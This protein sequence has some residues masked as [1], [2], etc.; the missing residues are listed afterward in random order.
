MLKFEQQLSSKD[1]DVLRNL[2]SKRNFLAA[3]KDYRLFYQ[4]F[5][6]FLRTFSANKQG[7][8]FRHYAYFLKKSVYKK[9]GSFTF[10]ISGLEN[11]GASSD[12]VQEEKE[13][14]VKDLELGFG[15]NSLAT[16]FSFF[17]RAREDN[18]PIF[19]LN[20]IYN[21][22]LDE[23]LDY[24]SDEADE[25]AVLTTG[26]LLD[27]A[28][29][30]QNLF[31]LYQ[32]IAK[33]LLANKKGLTKYIGENLLNDFLLLFSLSSQGAAIPRVDFSKFPSK[34]YLLENTVPKTKPPGLKLGNCE[35]Y[36]PKNNTGEGPFKLELW[37]SAS[38]KLGVLITS[39]AKQ[40]AGA[41]A[42]EDLQRGEFEAFVKAK[43]SDWLNQ[44]IASTL[45]ADRLYQK[46]KARL[47][48]ENI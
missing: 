37:L 17:L 8:Y 20:Q 40:K 24:E 25:N 30:F 2:A 14:T 38:D 33:T 21:D 39:E 19:S 6:S 46:F 43:V 42:W 15:E 13:Y 12:Y 18:V 36:Y 5:R 44:I 11:T 3:L 31:P 27:F 22:W 29:Y 35:S 45:F 34:S 26:L 1:A 4:D 10:P 9:L 7:W 23:E 47:V 48:L 28:T 41:P 32:R 16:G